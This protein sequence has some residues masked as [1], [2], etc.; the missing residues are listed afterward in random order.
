MTLCKL[1]NVYLHIASPIM[2]LQTPSGTQAL[3]VV[4]V[5]VCSC[6]RLRC[7][8]FNAWTGTQLRLMKRVCVHTGHE[9]GETDREAASLYLPIDAKSRIL[10]NTPPP[11]PI[12]PVGSFPNSV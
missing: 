5:S 6:S 11:P 10:N 3:S 1:F 7:S 9:R 4:N 2:L 8:M 12:D